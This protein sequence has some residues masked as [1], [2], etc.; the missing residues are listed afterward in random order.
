MTHIGRPK[1]N[2]IEELRVTTVAKHL[3]KL[4]KH[5]KGMHVARETVGPSVQA[6]LEKLKDSEILYLENVRFQ[7]AEEKNDPAFIKALASLGEIYVNEA[8]PSIHTYEEA[9]TCGVARLLPA[10]AGFQ[11]EH[12]ID[13]LAGVTEDPRRPLLLIISGAK[14]ET[15]IPVIRRFLT[16]ADHILLG[17]CIANTFVA[18]RGF[19]VGA[20]RY[21]QKEVEFA[22]E[23]MLES[24][25]EG[26]AKVQVPWDVVVASEAAETATKLD[27]PVEDVSGDMSIFD[28]GKV[29][30]ERYRKLIEQAGTIIWN[31]PV[32]YYELNRF[33]H[34]T[35]RI[36]EALAT[37]TKHGARTIVGGGDTLDFHTRY[38]YP[39]DVYS[40]VSTGGGA[41]LEFLASEKPLPALVPLLAKSER[42]AVVV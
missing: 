6:Q 5:C 15:K 27:L 17:G 18:A 3:Q 1:G 32:G 30:I 2:V 8:F 31:G 7:P 4:L 28:I 29:T 38:E 14:M 20:S 21:G 25:K 23:I 35:K 26:M 34:G 41:M 37:A 19:D 11:L 22:Q 39:L 40:F 9:S 12:E 33:S 42:Q 24:E 36:A 16:T 13:A 10:F